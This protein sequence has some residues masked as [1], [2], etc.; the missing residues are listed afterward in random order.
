MIPPGSSVIPRRGPPGART[1]GVTTVHGLGRKLQARG[2]RAERT[3]AGYEA[4]YI[5]QSSLKAIDEAAQSLL[6]AFDVVEQAADF[7]GRRG[8][9]VSA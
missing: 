5:C 6:G 1:Y 8:A 4:P 9:S 2:N 7:G 3:G